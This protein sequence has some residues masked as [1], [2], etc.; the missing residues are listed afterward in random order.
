[1]TLK[2]R[3][4]FEV[5]PSPQTCLVSVSLISDL[6]VPVSL[7]IQEHWRQDYNDTSDIMNH[8]LLNLVL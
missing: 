2:N 3:C 5:T 1:M 7:W 8:P 6:T 4:A